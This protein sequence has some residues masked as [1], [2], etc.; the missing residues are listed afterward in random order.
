MPYRLWVEGKT[1]QYV[2]RNLAERQ[3]LKETIE[4]RTAGSYSELIEMNLIS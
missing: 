2:I 1:D 4:V 3:Q